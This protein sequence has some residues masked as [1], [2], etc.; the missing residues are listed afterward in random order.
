MGGTILTNNNVVNGQATDLFINVNPATN[1]LVDS[2]GRERFFHGTNVVFKHAPFHPE[3][4]GYGE[5]TFSEIDMK[6]LQRLGL[7]TIRLGMKYF[8]NFVFF[9]SSIFFNFIFFRLR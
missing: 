6:I 3:T 8:F 4:E 2:V 1:M 5:N 7:N 9:F